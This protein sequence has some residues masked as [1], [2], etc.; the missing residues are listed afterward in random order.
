IE[1]LKDKLIFLHQVNDRQLSH[2]YQLAELM[3]YPSIFEGFGLPVA[4]AQAS[5]CPVITSKAGALPETGADGA[6]YVEAQNPD[7]I[8]QGIQKIL[9][10]KDYRNELIQK[11]RQ[12]ARRFAPENY[13]QQLMQ[14]YKQLAHA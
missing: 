12:N 6:H 3:L 14:F 4:E 10:N 13:A 5:G 1:P 2:L 7:E 8:N 9:Q 11:G